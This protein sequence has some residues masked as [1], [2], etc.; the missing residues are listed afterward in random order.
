[1]PAIFSR[2][3]SAY[4][5]LPGEVVLPLPAGLYLFTVTAASRTP[6]NAME[7]LSLPAVNVCLGPGVKSDDVEFVDRLIG[8]SVNLIAC[9][10]GKIYFPTFSNGLKDVGRYLG[11][12]WN[13]PQASG[14]AAPFLRR[15]WELDADGALKRELVGYN[16]DDCRAAE[17]VADA[18]V[19]ICGDG[20][21]TA[22]EEKPEARRP[23]KFDSKEGLLLVFKREKK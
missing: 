17:K 21:D 12:D 13:W 15:A 3:L 22:T 18:L 14:A 2:V 8:T 11:F 6:A 7:Q 19:R 9:I 20:V 10:Y 4:A 1:M 23:K 16:L 5:L